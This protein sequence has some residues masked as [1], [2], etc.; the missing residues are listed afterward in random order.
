VPG[1]SALL[2]LAI[3]G[4][5]P[6]DVAD[7]LICY[8]PDS[9]TRPTYTRKQ[10]VSMSTEAQIQLAM[11]MSVGGSK[12]LYKGDFVDPDA[13]SPVTSEDLKAESERKKSKYKKKEKDRL[14]RHASVHILN[15]ILDT[16]EDENVQQQV[17]D[18]F[19]RD[20]KESQGFSLYE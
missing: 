11:K 18:E 14:M 8:E 7:L 10:L 19:V 3:L 9:P 1:E 17:S 13:W 12:S 16:I 4:S 6:I 15:G 20:R 5:L 2:K